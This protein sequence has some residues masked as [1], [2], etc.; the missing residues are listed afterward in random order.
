MDVFI[1]TKNSNKFSES[2]II[3]RYHC[4]VFF[5]QCYFFSFQSVI[6]ALIY[7]S[8]C[9][10]GTFLNFNGIFDISFFIHLS[11]TFLNFNG[12]LEISLFVHLSGTF[13]NNLVLE[14]FENEVQFILLVSTCR[15]FE[16]CNFAM[17]KI[18]TRKYSTWK[19]FGELVLKGRL[20]IS[21]KAVIVYL[22]CSW[23]VA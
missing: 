16:N 3:P 12:T 7:L 23:K 20:V 6:V 15:M 22:W 2:G 5:F 10:S 21:K 13:L 1:A 19:N 18:F 14:H 11:W 8:V 17:F 4:T 9:L